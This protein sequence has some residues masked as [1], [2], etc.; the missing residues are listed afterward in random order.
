[1]ER[2]KVIFQAAQGLMLPLLRYRRG[3]SRDDGHVLKQTD[4]AKGMVEKGVVRGWKEGHHVRFEYEA[5]RTV[6][7]V[8]IDEP[9]G[10]PRE[11][12]ELT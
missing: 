9:E 3:H 2:L 8:S 6:R 7:R 12:T 5:S 11:W 4:R 1:M 10:R